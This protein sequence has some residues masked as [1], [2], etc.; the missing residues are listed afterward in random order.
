[1]IAAPWS[2]LALFSVISVTSVAENAHK[3]SLRNRLSKFTSITYRKRPRR[4]FRHF[5]H[6]FPARNR[7][8]AFMCI[9]ARAVEIAQCIIS[10]PRRHRFKS[11]ATRRAHA[12]SRNHLKSTKHKAGRQTHRHA[13]SGFFAR[14]GGPREMPRQTGG[15]LKPSQFAKRTGILT[16]RKRH[17]KLTSQQQPRIRP[18][19][20]VSGGPR[21]AITSSINPQSN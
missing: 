18:F 4:G 19:Q 8:P 1:M 20:V 9:I 21:P 3:K 17:V 10:R 5:E 14:T 15:F 11:P 6:I 16:P 2:Y 12:A 13:K 7:R